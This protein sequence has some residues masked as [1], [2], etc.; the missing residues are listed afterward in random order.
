[1]ADLK[2]NVITQKFPKKE[3]N[4]R[5][6][7]MATV[8]GD[9]HDIGKNIVC[10]I[11][12][13]YG[14]NVIDLGKD[15]ATEKIIEAFNKYNPMAIG[16]SA[17]MTTTV[18]SMEYSI[19]ELKKIQGMCPIFVGGAVITPEIAKDINADYYSKDPLELISILRNEGI[20]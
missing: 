15:V 2:F 12:E 11:L 16:L 4:K 17:L 19:K 8:K 9:V 3:N 6:I 20:E 13:S 14:Y 10:V 5:P 18:I 7:I 1:M